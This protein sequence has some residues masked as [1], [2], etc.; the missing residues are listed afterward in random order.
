M[1]A[2]YSFRKQRNP[3]N[4]LPTRTNRSSRCQ[5]GQVDDQRMEPFRSQF[6]DPRG[7]RFL[8]CLV[9][10]PGAGPAPVG[11]D[12][13]ATPI[14]MSKTIQEGISGATLNVIAGG[15]HLTPLECPVQIAGEI[16]KLLEKVST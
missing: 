7:D 16:E 1:Y 12:D 3:P 6:R 11:E 2:T 9:R 8:R 14:A 15:R 4:P 5:S 13:Q 10:R